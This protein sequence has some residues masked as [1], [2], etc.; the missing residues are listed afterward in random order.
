MEYT[1]DVMMY[2]LRQDAVPYSSHTYSSSK[3]HQA[4]TLVDQQRDNSSESA[5]AVF[6]LQAQTYW[7]CSIAIPRP[8]LDSKQENSYVM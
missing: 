5:H 1:D 8:S 6:M 4:R 7:Q 3:Q 2:I